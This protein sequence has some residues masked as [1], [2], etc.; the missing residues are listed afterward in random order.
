MDERRGGVI[1]ALSGSTIT[2]DVYYKQQA[3]YGLTLPEMFSSAWMGDYSHINRA[4]VSQ[5]DHE[6]NPI[7]LVGDLV[8]VWTPHGVSWRAPVRLERASTRRP[9]GDS[10]L[11]LALAQVGVVGPSPFNNVLTVEPTSGQIE[12]LL[13]EP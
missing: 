4:V 2:Q 10:V 11:C 1:G 13:G 5:R 7:L 8:P 3:M 9:L 6:P 12:T